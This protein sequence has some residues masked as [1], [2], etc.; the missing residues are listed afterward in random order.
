MR[1]IFFKIGK[2]WSAFSWGYFSFVGVAG[3]QFIICY[4]NYGQKM[5][6]EEKYMRA[7]DAKHVSDLAKSRASPK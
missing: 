2:L 6:E 5:Q 1:I 3:T 4:R 7:N